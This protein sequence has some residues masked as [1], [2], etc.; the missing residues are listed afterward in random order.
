[1]KKTRINR[2]KKKHTKRKKSLTHKARGI[3][4][5]DENLWDYQN[6]AMHRDK[7]KTLK[8]NHAEIKNILSK[9]L[10]SDLAR[11][12]VGRSPLNTLHPFLKED[13]ERVADKF[14]RNRK[15]SLSSH[16]SQTYK[17]K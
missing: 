12:I 9:R 3:I 11:N 13:I 14:T 15:N 2:K 1:M 17:R 6:V 4:Y 16:K 10:N 5:H 8:Q 7:I